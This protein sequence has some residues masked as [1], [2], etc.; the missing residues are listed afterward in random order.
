MGL[1]GSRGRWFVLFVLC[2]LTPGTIATETC[3]SFRLDRHERVPNGNSLHAT[4]HMPADLITVAWHSPN[5]SCFG[6][7][8]Y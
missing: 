6:G 8:P 3:P 7:H 1:R 4:I 5:I 2:G